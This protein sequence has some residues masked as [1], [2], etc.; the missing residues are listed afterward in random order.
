MMPR[1]VVYL[2]ADQPIGSW[3]LDRDKGAFTV[4]LTVTA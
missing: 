2:F 4:T 1:G 3:A